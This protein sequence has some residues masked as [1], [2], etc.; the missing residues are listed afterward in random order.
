MS[1]QLGNLSQ[2][3]VISFVQHASANWVPAFLLFM[4][5]D[6]RVCGMPLI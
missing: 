6:G 5:L 1:Y 2:V 3:C 4:A